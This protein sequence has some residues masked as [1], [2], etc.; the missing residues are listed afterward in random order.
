MNMSSIRQ[1]VKNRHLFISIAS[2]K[3]LNTWWPTKQF[4]TRARSENK[5]TRMRPIL[6]TQFAT[7]WMQTFEEETYFCGTTCT[8][9]LIMCYPY[10]SQ[11]LPGIILPPPAYIYSRTCIQFTRSI[12]SVTQALFIKPVSSTTSRPLFIGSVVH[13]PHHEIPPSTTAPSFILSTGC[14]LIPALHDGKGFQT[15][16]IV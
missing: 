2:A 6:S 5:R 4:K 13:I 7:Y 1:W 16:T 8:Y 15:C 10:A 3:F 12:V 11:V 9:K 14:F